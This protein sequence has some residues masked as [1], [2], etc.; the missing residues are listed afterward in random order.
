MDTLF[1]DIRYAS[2]KLAR[3]PGFTVIAALTL[4]LAIGANT[5][6]FSVVHGVVFK[7]LPF[8]DPDEIVRVYNVRKNGRMPLSALDFTDFR[9][10]ARSLSHMAAYTDFD[11]NLTGGAEPERLRANAVSASFWSV[12]GIDP[13]LGRPFAPN[14]D[15]SSAAPVAIISD[16]LWHRRFGGERAVIGRTILLD[17]NPTTIVG[18]APPAFTY[19]EKADVWT[20]L[21]FTP[22]LLDPGNRGAHW[23]GAIGRVAPGRT[24]EQV[25]R[26]MQAIARRLEQ[27][28]P[29]SNTGMGGAAMPLQR[30]LVGDL[31]GKLLVLL[32]AVGFV[33]LI[34]CA[35]VANLLLVRAAGR[36]TEI[37]VRAALGAGRWRIVRQLVIESVV[38]SLLGGAVGVL[39]AVWG[40]DLLM[41]I[42]PDT[43]PRLSEVT[44]SGSVLA[45]TAAIAIGTGFL[46]GLIPALYAARANVG[47][48][49]KEGAR[50][51]SSRRGAASLRSG[52]VLG[53][54]AMAVILLVGAGLLIKSFA[55]LVAVDPGFRAERVMTFSISAPANKYPDRTTLR[56]LT[57]DIVEA[58]KALP[59][60][61]SVAAV[62]GLPMTGL[63]ARTGV[64]IVGAP[65]DPPSERKV[66]TIHIVTPEYFATIGIELLRGRDFTTT[67]RSGS[68][69]VTIVNEEFARRYFDGQDPVGKQIQTG[70]GADT[71]VGPGGE[72]YG[73]GEI[74]GVVR[75]VK[76]DG[77][78][79]EVMPQTYLV[80]DQMATNDLSVVVRSTADPS[81]LAAAARRQL[82][83]ID[84]DLPV[85]GLRQLSEV[86]QASVAQPRF[87]TL[88]LTLFAG[89]ALTLAAVGIYG[90]ISY[91]VSQRTRELGIRIALGASA[92]EVV[93][94]VLSQGMTITLGG[95]VIGL[96]ASYWATRALA[97]FLFNV[98]P[99]DAMTYAAVAIVLAA[100]AAL[101]CWVPARRA[102][103]VD[104][105]VAI[106]SE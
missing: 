30:Y 90:V 72:V 54:M 100:A 16:A 102:S 22:F 82:R 29:E 25:D 36:E 105:V 57:T 11:V 58:M 39:L 87:Y 5:A 84:P 6:I 101:A 93:K 28:Y 32:G 13:A 27:Q 49:L 92:G 14:E 15:Q 75:N 24:I 66:T 74:V 3:T 91:A 4:A 8:R 83:S 103:R 53:E 45:F 69:L 35:N 61:Q 85:F 59:G 17:G 65:P 26:E 104:P 23:L 38:L 48:A 1:Q 10:Q 21:V 98:E 51:M 80:R 70:W 41:A 46:F 99:L 88:L 55:K 40:V 78:S 34:A 47:G 63:F 97:G 52:L 79:D 64:Q 73:G 37:A 106:R 42:A 18:V 33:L 60:A 62:S 43:V 31:Q 86:V 94:H 12:L 7:P 50:G 9:A 77:L 19:P 2:R 76:Q 67:D 44:V 68:P 20:P 89:I 81:T 95:L 56:T 71:S 96:V